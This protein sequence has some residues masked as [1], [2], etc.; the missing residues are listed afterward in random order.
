MHLRPFLAALLLSIPVLAAQVTDVADAAD[1]KHPLELDLDVTFDHAHT[2]TRIT[3]E[4]STAGGILLVDELK[5]ART[6]DALNFR[7][8]VGLWH[9]L[10]LHVLAPLVVKDQQDWG[11]AVVNGVS[12]EGASTL[13]NNHIGIS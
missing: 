3:R 10:E 8:N 2:D 13:K 1:E 4:Q 9:D 12:V 5:H 11:Y 6:V 7:L